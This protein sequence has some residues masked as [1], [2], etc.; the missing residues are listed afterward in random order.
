M[1]TAGNHFRISIT[2]KIVLD[3]VVL[4]H[5]RFLVRPIRIKAI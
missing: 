4:G 2:K 3:L 1:L 5:L